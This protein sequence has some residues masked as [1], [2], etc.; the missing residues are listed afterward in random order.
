[1]WKD[2]G[3]SEIAVSVKPFSALYF[4]SCKVLI[5]YGLALYDVIVP[6]LLDGQGRK[7]H[8]F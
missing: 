7:D 5:S 1:M 2:P 6:V 3:G 8:L 4:S